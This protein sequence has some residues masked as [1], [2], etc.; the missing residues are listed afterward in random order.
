MP[1]WDVES[2]LKELGTVGFHTEPGGTVDVVSGEKLFFVT[3][4]AERFERETGFLL[5]SIDFYFCLAIKITPW[6]G[7]IVIVGQFRF[8]IICENLVV[9]IVIQWN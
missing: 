8:Y 6:K 7:Q 4:K 9:D 2:D 5:L 1:W 3:D